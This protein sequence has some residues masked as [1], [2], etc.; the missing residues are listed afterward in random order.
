MIESVP[1]LSEGRDRESIEQ[2]ADAVRASGVRLLD[3]HADSDHNR[4]VLTFVGERDD[5]VSGV[6]AL[7]EAALER[8]DISQH[9]GE[10]PRIGAVDVVPFVPLSG[11]TMQDCIDVAREAGEAIGTRFGIPV[12]LYEA[13]A[14]HPERR[15]LADLRRGG[16]AGIAER[17]HTDAGKPDFGPA[18]LHP[19]AGAM[20]VG[21]R[22]F[23][24]AYNVNLASDDIDGAKAIAAAIRASDGGLPGLKALGVMLHT[25]GL[26]QVTMNLTDITATTV[27]E[28]FDAVRR[29]ADRRGVG[30]L[31]SEVV[32]LLPRAALAGAAT[33]DLLLTRDVEE[34]VLEDRITSS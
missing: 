1:N 34:I 33:D 4:S 14:T 12:F 16:P 23:L 18:R 20:A 10:H 11:S 26:A 21:A 32:G 5:V 31:E 27:P 15:N 8:I 9:H 24:V 6:L 2:I 13:A 25:R 3:I 29:E 19:S 22:P 17:M 28:A 7:I 30:V